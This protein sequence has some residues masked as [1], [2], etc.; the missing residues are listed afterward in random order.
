M[1]HT[2][3]D[4]LAPL[5]DFGE[6][7]SSLGVL[8]GSTIVRGV[9]IYLSPSWPA[10]IDTVTGAKTTLL[11]DR[12]WKEVFETDDQGVIGDLREAVRRGGVEQAVVGQ[13]PIHRI[14]QLAALV[15]EARDPSPSEEI[16]E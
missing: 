9:R 2:P 8:D 14:Y 5:E 11:K 13:K 16:G 15:L 6:G 12:T 1:T 4:S 3:K 10:W 7:V